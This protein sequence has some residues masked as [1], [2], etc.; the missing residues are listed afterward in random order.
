MGVT[1]TLALIALAAFLWSRSLQTRSEECSES[2]GCTLG[3]GV[4][5]GIALW[6]SIGVGVFALISVW[7]TV[8]LQFAGSRREPKG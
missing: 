5:A 4:A 1:I 7:I 6:V 8:R 3:S 2:F